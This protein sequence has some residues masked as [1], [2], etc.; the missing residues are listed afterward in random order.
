MKKKLLSAVVAACLMFGSAAAI[1][2]NAFTDMTSVTASADT[3]SDGFVYNIHGNEAWIIGYTGSKTDITIPDKLPNMDGG[4][5]VTI[6]AD[7]T[8]KDKNIKSVILN[9]SLL[10]IG[11]NAFNGCKQLVS[12][13]V[14]SGGSAL[15][16]IGASAFEGCSKLSTLSYFANSAVKSIGNYAFKGCSVLPLVNLPSKVTDIGAYAF[17]ACSKLEKVTGLENTKVSSLYGTF[18]DCS[19][20]QTFSLPSTLISIQDGVFLNCKAIKSVDMSNCKNMSFIGLSAFQRCE[21]LTTVKLPNSITSINGSAF[22]YCRYLTTINF[23]TELTS[24]GVDAF[25]YAPRVNI[26]EN[27]LKNTKLVSIGAHAFADRTEEEWGYGYWNQIDRIF[28]PS[29]VTSIGDYAFGYHYIEVTHDGGF[30]H[31]MEYCSCSVPQKVTIVTYENGGAAIEYATKN[32]GAVLLDKMTHTHNYTGEVTQKATCIAGGV[33]TYTC[34]YCRDTYTETIKKLNHD[35]QEKPGY[36]H[37]LKQATPVAAG[38]KQINCVNC[39]GLLEGGIKK[40][41][42]P[43]TNRRIAGDNRY[44][45]ARYIADTYREVTGDKYAK[46]TNLIVAS[47]ND[48]ADA[49]SASYLSSK[50]GAPIINVAAGRE[51]EVLT[52]IKQ[53][54]YG[55]ANIYVIG[56][57]GA[58][59]KSFFDK[60]KVSFK[61]AQRV[62]GQNRYETNLAVFQ[63]IA[64][65]GY[66]VPAK[67]IVATGA[68][69]ADALSASAAGFPIILVPGKASSLP[70]SC[71]TV[72]KNFK[73]KQFIIAGGTGAV[74]NGIQNQLAEIGSVKRLSGKNRYETSAKIA[75]EFFASPSAVTL[76]TGTNFPDGLCGG[77]LSNK[78]NCPLLLTATGRTADAKAYAN[79]KKVTYAWILGGKTLVSDA[80]VKTILTK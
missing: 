41:V 74:S 13:V 23:P 27:S 33:I 63:L 77:L 40:E 47:G 46:Y 62:A 14:P 69:Y 29:S 21:N 1:P 19:K 54:T 32:K 51:A 52:Y 24:I 10:G 75:A 22:K 71:M 12:V 31:K 28:I 3:T 65:L 8:F 61:S 38:E 16:E 18:R 42:I 72:A 78:T 73:N 70:E 4:K 76:A 57:E 37:V 59:S 25:R 9:K 35:F 60:L 17:D 6:I 58:V 26:T 56:G 15:S 80:D 49:L 66:N 34:T 50:L 43:K 55:N 2:Q 7:G 36:I 67:A 45:T 53:S 44:A 5:P 64:K 39:L 11:N 30:T 79:S 68:E 48:F 20:L